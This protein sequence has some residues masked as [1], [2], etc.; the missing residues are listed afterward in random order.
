MSAT[1]DELAS[2]AGAYQ[3]L[4]RLW[5]QEVDEAFLASLLDE[6]LCDFFAAAGGILPDD[7]ALSTLEELAVD[8]CQLFLG[9]A[10][11]LPPFQSVWQRG[12]LQGEPAESMQHYVSM[13][14]CAASG[15]MVDHLGVQLEVMGRLL[16]VGSESAQ[17]AN[18]VVDLA[19][20]YFAEHLN[21]AAPLFESA[22]DRATTDFYRSTIGMTR[23][24]LNSEA[25]FW[26]A[27]RREAIQ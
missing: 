3:L 4:A 27:T 25:Q 23:D 13:A 20:A 26:A 6:P 21:W 18:D 10:N 11:H 24:F 8:F 7:V 14:G 12:Q 9:P 22:I 16:D 2:L 19:A 5:Q 1:V 17:H 15:L